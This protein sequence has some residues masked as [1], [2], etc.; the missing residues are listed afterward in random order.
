MTE[1]LNRML[2]VCF[3]LIP[4]CRVFVQQTDHRIDPSQLRTSAMRS[5]LLPRGI[6]IK[7]DLVP[8]LLLG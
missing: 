8:D 2:H 1:H 3:R 6:L 7:R 4:Q 5:L